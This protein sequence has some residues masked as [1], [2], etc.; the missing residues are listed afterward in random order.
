M[1][2]LPQAARARQPREEEHR[3]PHL[4]KVLRQGRED[5]RRPH[6]CGHPAHPALDG[7]VCPADGAVRLPVY[8]HSQQL[9]ARGRPGLRAGD[10]AAPAGQ[11]H[12]QDQ[13]GVHPDPRHPRQVGRLRGHDAGGRLQLPWPGRERRHGVH[14]AQ[15]LGRARGRGHRLHPAGQ[16]RVVRHQGRAD[17]RGQPADRAGPGPV[18]RFRHVAAG[19]QRCRRGGAAGRTQH[20]AAEGRCGQDPGRGPSEHPGERTAAAAER[21]S[22]AGPGDGPVGRRHLHLHPAD[23]GPG[24]RQ[25]LLLPGPHQAGEHACRCPVPHRRRVAGPHLY[26]QQ[27]ADRCQRRARDD[28]AVH[29]GPFGDGFGTAVAVALQRLFGGEHQRRGRAGQF[30]GP[31]D[32]HDGEHRD[33]RS[34]A[35]LRL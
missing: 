2:Q 19:P 17:L 29:G 15:A 1:R 26:A 9:P 21:G 32:D 10:R 5:L 13:R 18:R 23:A 3:L 22:R 35:G 20:A 11:H 33:Q 4:R 14:Q 6:R 28:S 7:G 12:E 16:W 25:R 8:P 30:L 34:A 31:G 24:V 27:P